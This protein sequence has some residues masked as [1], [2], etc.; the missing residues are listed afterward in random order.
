MNRSRYL[1]LF[2]LF[3]VIIQDPALAQTTIELDQDGSFFLSIP[4]DD[5]QPVKIDPETGELRATA[6]SGFSCS[7]GSCEDVQLSFAATDG[8]IFTVNGGTGS[9]TVPETGAVRFD[10]R[11][12]GAW[13]CEGTGLP[14]T[15]WNQAG[16]LPWGTLPSVGVSELA[17]GVYQAGMT[18]S[19]GAANAVSSPLI[20][21][22]VTE[23]TTEIPTECEGRQPAQ[24]VRTQVC[25]SNGIYGPDLTVDCFSYE[26]LFGSQF[27][28]E[29][30]AKDFF[31]ERDTY[32]ALE[33][34]TTGLTESNGGWAFEGASIPPT[35]GGARIMT[36]SQCPGDFDQTAIEAEMGTGCYVKTGGFTPSVTWK[37]SGTFGSQ[38]ELE[39]DKTYYLNIIFSQ[40]PA[41]T[42]PAELQWSCTDP[43]ADACGVNMQSSFNQ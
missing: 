40:D 23:S 11:A 31:L 15:T 17:P 19:N 41:G 6:A 38:C 3:A 43:E 20:E 14:G 30:R 16:R 29:T 35:N 8:G 39:L 24:A 9:V 26:S 21:V 42:P 27:P 13:T 4:L 37:R 22:T 5:T 12:R 7:T 10:W 36:L 18:C 32:V 33:F 1:T 2:A 34:N 25:E 28:G